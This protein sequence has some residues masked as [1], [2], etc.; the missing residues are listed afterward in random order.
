MTSSGGDNVLLSFPSA[1][2]RNKTLPTPPPTLKPK[3]DRYVSRDQ[4]CL[5]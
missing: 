5:D 1:A 3:G 4:T 2:M